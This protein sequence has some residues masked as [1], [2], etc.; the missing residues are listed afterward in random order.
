MPANSPESHQIGAKVLQTYCFV[1]PLASM[2]YLRQIEFAMNQNPEG[3]YGVT[4]FEDPVPMQTDQSSE[5]EL[6]DMLAESLGYKSPLFRPDRYRVDEEVLASG[7]V[8]ECGKVVPL[9]FVSCQQT[10][11]GRGRPSR[12]D[13]AIDPNTGQPYKWNCCGIYPTHNHEMI[14]DRCRLV[15]HDRSGKIKRSLANTAFVCGFCGR[16]V[17]LSCH[18]QRK[19]LCFEYNDPKLPMVPTNVLDFFSCNQCHFD[20]KDNRKR[21][22]NEYYQVLPRKDSGY[23]NE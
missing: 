18:W 12:A 6:M 3:I 17:C 21:T 10:K 4:R 15:F 11:R 14:V 9:K 19:D 13:Y 5:D 22:A 20:G 8:E 23:F 16:I 2:P 1:E 7:T